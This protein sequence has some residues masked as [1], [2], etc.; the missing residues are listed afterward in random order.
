MQ[1]TCGQAP[2]HE[3][4][5]D[6]QNFASLLSDEVE[7][8]LGHQVKQ[9]FLNNVAP[10]FLRSQIASQDAEGSHNADWRQ[11]AELAVRH[12][13]TLSG[14]LAILTG[15]DPADL[16]SQNCLTSGSQIS[17]LVISFCRHGLFGLFQG[18][19]WCRYE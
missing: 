3:Q 18:L 8:L 5:A 9:E 2:Q 16:Q 13:G 4:Q 17:Q 14:S 19:A 11:Q 7:S 12:A 10:L 15:Q 1:V 6:L